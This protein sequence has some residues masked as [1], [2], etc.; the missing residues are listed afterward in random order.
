MCLIEE[1]CCCAEPIVPRRMTPHKF[2]IPHARATFGTAGQ[3]IHILP[4]APADGQPALVEIIDL[5]ELLGHNRETE[6]LKAFPGP[7]V[8]YCTIFFLWF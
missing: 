4:T 1:K 5:P 6:K 8:R 3:L 2:I 7:L